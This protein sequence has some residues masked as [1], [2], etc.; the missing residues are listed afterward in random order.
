[1][2]YAFH[3]LNFEK[4]FMIGADG[5]LVDSDVGSVSVNLGN[6][7]TRVFNGPVS[8]LHFKHSSR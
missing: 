3:W 1:V 5:V 2:N 6:I 8:T 7:H 4:Q